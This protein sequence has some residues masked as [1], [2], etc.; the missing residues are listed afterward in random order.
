LQIEK[1]KM[2]IEETTTRQNIKSAAGRSFLPGRTNVVA[3]M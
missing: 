3:N 2:D 1:W